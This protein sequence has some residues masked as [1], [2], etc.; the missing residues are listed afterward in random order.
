MFSPCAG[1][2]KRS[3][4][5]DT[6]STRDLILRVYGCMHQNDINIRVRSYLSADRLY[7]PLRRSLVNDTPKKGIFLKKE[8][9]Q[10][11]EK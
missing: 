11:V 2:R 3:G 10:T 9:N 5:N 8:V 7:D 4:G 1:K 6:K